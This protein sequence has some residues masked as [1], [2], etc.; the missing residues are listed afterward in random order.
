MGTA[1][2]PAASKGAGGYNAAHEPQG[3]SIMTRFDR[4]AQPYRSASF[5]IIMCLV[6][7]SVGRPAFGTE[8]VPT[9]V[10]VTVYSSADPAG[11]DP[12][13]FIGQ[14]RAGYD[15]QF[16]SQVPGFGVVKEVR[17]VD[18]A[19]GLAAL[20]FTDVAQFIDPTTV[21]FT[22][23]SAQD[24]ATVLEQNFEFDLASPDKVLDKYIDREIAV[25]MAQGDK[26]E[27]V[28][29]TLL[30]TAGGGLLL[31]TPAGLR[32]IS[33]RGQQIQLG[34]L[35]GGLISRPTLVWKVRS[36][37]GGKRTVRTTYQT[38]GMTW[39]ADYNLVIDANEKLAD[40]AAWV[41][42][43]NVSGAGYKNAKLKLIAG[44][45][46]RVQPQNQMRYAMARSVSVDLSMKE[47]GFEEK[48]FFEY[49]LY[50]LPRMTD[51]PQNGT[52][53]ITLF[54]SARGV[55]IEKL[56]VY[57]GLP[58][59]AHWGYFG[60]PQQDRQFGNQSNKKV[61]VYLRF[62]NDEKSRLGM[63]LPRGKVR[64]YKQDDADG[65]L[66]FIGEDLIDHTPKDEKVLVK[67]GQSFDVVGERTQ[68]DFRINTDRKVMHESFKIQLRNHK[69]EAQK[70]IIKETLYRWSEWEITEKSDPF[71]KIDARTIHFEVM[72]PANGEKTVRYSVKYVW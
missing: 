62:R 20:R 4:L 72:V 9:G 58:E 57:Y 45:V 39:R 26:T 42:L 11:F 59:A 18:L 69:P 38:S 1:F 41:S 40:L 68:T 49:H 7:V 23:L 24:P 70:V 56:L 60:A 55:P 34:E 25:V 12:Q 35:P 17:E 54:P 14:Q 16:A 71:E 13:Q 48:A 8:D 32:V 5:S 36:Q 50:T 3:E 27:T 29:G 64:V 53:Q 51:I 52:Q 19:A 10:S 44:D 21:S 46:Q 33:G 15:A 43:L 30:S 22:D 65:T 66:E 28:T 61:D 37:N 2:N 63:P 31:N 47:A 67:L 6:L